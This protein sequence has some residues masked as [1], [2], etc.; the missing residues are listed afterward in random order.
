MASV[1]DSYIGVVDEVTYGTAVPVTRFY[2]LSKESVSGKYERIESGAMTVGQRVMRAD[3]FA[4][5]AKGA[6]GSVELEVLDKSFAFWLK[7]MLGNVASGTKDADGFTTYTGTI[8]DLSGKSFTMEIGRADAAGGLNQF[9]YPGG[10]VSGW[11]L[12]N[13]VDGVLSLSVDAVFAK[14]TVRTGSP[15]T[16]TY[17]AGAK[18][19][20]YLGGTVSVDNA[21]LAVSD[22]SV[23][24]D[25]GLKD[26][27]WAIGV[28]RREPREQSARK[29]EFSFKG[30]FDSMTAYNKASAALASGALGNIVLTWVGVAPDPAKPTIV[31]SITV[32]M[33]NGRFDSATPNIEAGKLPDL[34]ISGVA[35]NGTGNDA[36]TVAYKTLDTAA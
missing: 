27:R 34:A 20:T 22:V 10:K 15:V 29:L 30:D 13:Q 36:I 24:G 1:F 33:P 4:P 3:R 23:K 9:V 17:P 8:A 26:D 32:T 28:G 19:F 7:H 18:L 16:P 12:S 25:N 21:T 31:P 2:E 6:D 14:E 35:L 5:N 11:E